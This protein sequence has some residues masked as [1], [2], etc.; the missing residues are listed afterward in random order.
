MEIYRYEDL[1]VIYWNCDGIYGSMHSGIWW[2]TMELY[3]C[4]ISRCYMIVS[5]NYLLIL[6]EFWVEFVNLFFM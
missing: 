6:L 5:E 4:N 1:L 2:K 3:G